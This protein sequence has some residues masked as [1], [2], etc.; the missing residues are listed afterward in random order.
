MKNR[1]YS[2]LWGIF[3]FTGTVRLTFVI[4]QQRRFWTRFEDVRGLWID[5]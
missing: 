5:F 2:S 3:A 1:A 4:Q